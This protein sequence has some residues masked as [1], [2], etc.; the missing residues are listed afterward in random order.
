MFT[1]IRVFCILSIRINIIFGI[2]GYSQPWI[3]NI[4]IS[5]GV[6]AGK[7]SLEIGFNMWVIAVCA[8]VWDTVCILL[9]IGC[10]AREI[11]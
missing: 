7:I 9:V 3:I 10:F 6:T 8:I 1:W 5:V 2:V 11:G 4:V